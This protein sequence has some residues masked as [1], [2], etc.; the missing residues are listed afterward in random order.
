M[1]TINE[2]KTTINDYKTGQKTIEQTILTA[3][4]QARATCDLEGKESS[5]CLEAWEIVEE[6]QA[7]KELQKQA[8]HRKTDLDIYCEMYPEALE[9]LIYDV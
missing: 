3:I 5:N 7:E 4:V 2:I 1:N 8:K 6:L 9:C